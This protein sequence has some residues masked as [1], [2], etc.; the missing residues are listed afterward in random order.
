VFVAGRIVYFLGYSTGVPAHRERGA[1][2][3]L[4]LV[5]LLLMAVASCVHLIQEDMPN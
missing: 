1:F 3:R 2:T 5:A 4:G